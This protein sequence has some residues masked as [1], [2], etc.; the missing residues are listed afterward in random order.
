M[1]LTRS[2]SL[3]TSASA[4]SSS[5]SYSLVGLLSCARSER[6]SLVFSRAFNCTKSPLERLLVT[7]RVKTVFEFLSPDFCIRIKSDNWSTEILPALLCFLPMKLVTSLE[8]VSLPWIEGLV[9]FYKAAV[10]ERPRVNPTTDYFLG[11]LDKCYVGSVAI[12][13]IRIRLDFF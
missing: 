11:D 9:P 10:P 4:S 1:D 7:L 5:P 6:N 3:H 2:F 13:L 8:G 12:A